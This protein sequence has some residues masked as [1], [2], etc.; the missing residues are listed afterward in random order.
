MALGG[1]VHRGNSACAQA[2]PDFRSRV[3]QRATALEY[4]MT[5]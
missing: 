1:A 3:P 5:D 4:Y 2:L